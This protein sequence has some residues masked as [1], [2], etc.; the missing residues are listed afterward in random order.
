MQEFNAADQQQSPTSAVALIYNRQSSTAPR[1]VA[2]G[3]GKLAAK[4]IET[5][6]QAG[7]FIKEDPDLLELLAHVP[8]NDEIPEELYLAVAEVLAF[9]YRINSRRLEEE[10]GRM[11]N[12]IHK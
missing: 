5:A 10:S 1:V 8:L 12:D 11:S 9:V 3:K 6:R 4:I 7:V 2:K